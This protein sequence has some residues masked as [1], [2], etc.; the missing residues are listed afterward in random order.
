MQLREKETLPQGYQ[1]H[2]RCVKDSVEAADLLQVQFPTDR[3]EWD[4]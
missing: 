1:Q 4:E 3:G 2:Q